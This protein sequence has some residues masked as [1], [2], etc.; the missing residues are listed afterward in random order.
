MSSNEK[1]IQP[2]SKK[3]LGQSCRLKKNLPVRSYTSVSENNRNLLIKY[4]FYM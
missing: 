1:P 2:E 3:P 4:V